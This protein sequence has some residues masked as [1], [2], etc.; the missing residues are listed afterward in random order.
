[1]G[2]GNATRVLG[3]TIVVPSRALLARKSAAPVGYG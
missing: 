1:M 2:Y 3:T